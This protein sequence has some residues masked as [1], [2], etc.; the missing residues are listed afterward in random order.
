MISTIEI[1]LLVL[2]AT[3]LTVLAGSVLWAFIYL[4]FKYFRE[5]K[6]GGNDE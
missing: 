3:V 1:Y 2:F 4:M 5:F 6:F